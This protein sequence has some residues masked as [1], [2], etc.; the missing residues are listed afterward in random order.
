VGF[1]ADWDEIAQGDA[2]RA[3]AVDAMRNTSYALHHL[4]Q[5]PER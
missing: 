2:A 4:A 1:A 5:G 3:L